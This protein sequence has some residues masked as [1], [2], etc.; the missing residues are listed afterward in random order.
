MRGKAGLANPD[1]SAMMDDKTGC[2]V[3]GSSEIC[4]ASE[5]NAGLIPVAVGPAAE[6]SE[7][8]EEMA[9]WIE[10]GSADACE[11]T[12]VNTPPTATPTG[13]REVTSAARP[14]ACDNIPES[15]GL[16]EIGRSLIW[17]ANEE[18]AGLTP[19]AMGSSTAERRDD[20]A[21]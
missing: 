7:I 1:A 21:G 2:A 19:V 14:E 8:K 15:A 5:D 20:T 11:A 4:D 6:I 13:T 16:A 3:T 10:V 18:M 12:F 17:A 9:G